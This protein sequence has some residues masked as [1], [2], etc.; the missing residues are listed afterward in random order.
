MTDPLKRALDRFDVPPLSPGRIERI[1]AAAMNDVGPASGANAIS[2]R[3]FDR[4]GAWRRGRQ[5]VIGSLAVGLL[6]ATAVASGLL[7]R[8]GIEVPVLTAMLAPTPPLATPKKLVAPAPRLGPRRPAAP[9]AGVAR[10][11]QADLPAAYR[12]F[13]DAL[14]LRDERR[15]RRESFAAAHP[16]IAARIEQRVRQELRARAAARLVAI[17]ADAGVPLLPEERRALLRAA[18]RDRLVAERMI[19]RRIVARQQRQA[20]TQTDEAIASPRDEVKA[21]PPAANVTGTADF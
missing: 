21:D 20:L 4:R 13:E 17:G 11:E 6:S 10:V 7:G 5:V 3:M 14:A 9:A 1:V 19:D 2:R 12:P 18:I 8:V 16:V 15:A